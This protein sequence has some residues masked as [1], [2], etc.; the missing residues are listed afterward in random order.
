VRQLTYFEFLDFSLDHQL[1]PREGLR[2]LTSDKP[3]SSA[4]SETMNGK[5]DLDL[6]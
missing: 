6:E 2:Q 4:I 3:L 5:A 1:G